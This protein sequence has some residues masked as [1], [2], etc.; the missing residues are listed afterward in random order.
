ME[1]PNVGPV[2]CDLICEKILTILLS[3]IDCSSDNTHNCDHVA[4]SK[5][6]LFS[7]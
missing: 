6:V 5:P 4:G 3:Y 1:L 2:D 7:S